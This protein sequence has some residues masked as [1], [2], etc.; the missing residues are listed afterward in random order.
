MNNIDSVKNAKTA[1]VVTSVSPGYSHTN[2]LYN[3]LDTCIHTAMSSVCRAPT[4]SFLKKNN[5]KHSLYLLSR[6]KTTF[7]SL[8]MRRS[9]KVA[10]SMVNTSK[11]LMVRHTVLRPWKSK[12]WRATGRAHRLGK[13]L[14]RPLSGY[15]LSRALAYRRTLLNSAA[16]EYFN[17]TI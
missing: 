6:A 2:Q 5:L 7:V 17:Y 15:K 8:K 9:Y 10:V 11:S 16:R 13:L 14:K 4:L 1:L 12:R 3:T